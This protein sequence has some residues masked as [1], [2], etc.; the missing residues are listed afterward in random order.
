MLNKLFSLN[1]W[2][3][4]NFNKVFES[5]HFNK[6][7]YEKIDL[8]LSDYA[9]SNNLTT[10]YIISAYNNFTNNYSNDIRNFIKTGKYPYEN[11]ANV[12]LDR[13]EYDVVLILSVVQSIHRHR[14]F[15]NIYNIS[16]DITGKTL[17]VG[18]GS[19]LELEFLN[20]EKTNPVIYDICI[21]D[22]VKKKYKNLEL[23]ET[24]FKG[25]NFE[26][27][28]I[29]AIELIEHLERPLSFLQI[30]YNSLKKNGIF[31]FTIAT[32]V[33]Q[34]DHL[35]NFADKYDFESSIK[36]IGF[37]IIVSETIIHE[38]I[39]SNLNASNTWYVLKKN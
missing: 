33:P 39:N 2:M 23:H 27:N 38:S 13:V 11:G 29:I 26:Y 35:S 10:D 12:Q 21:S 32:N 16:K 24:Y 22:Q 15:S 18:I 34:V 8:F 7:V 17:L 19:G 9:S 14:I 3:R 25:S 28:N 20:W 30:C 1:R 31:Y 6:F 36:L 37:E 5:T 4:I